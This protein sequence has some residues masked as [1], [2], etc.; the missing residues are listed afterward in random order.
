MVFSSSDG[1][2]CVNIL[3]DAISEIKK[4]IL[5]HYP[6]ETGGV[7][8]G[9][10]DENLRLA[11]IYLATESPKD[12]EYGATAFKRGVNDIV[13]NIT[14]AQKKLS[15]ELHY[16]GEWHSHPNN[17]PAASPTDLKQMQI[18][19]KTNQLGISVPLLLIVGGKPPLGLDW[20][21]SLHRYKKKPSLLLPLK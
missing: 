21:F 10:Y 3:P 20:Q 6:N 7:L 15:T 2:I 4:E 5:V 1:L 13:N 18:F 9:K 19:A 11:T 12:S 16:V 8:I 14:L 17:S